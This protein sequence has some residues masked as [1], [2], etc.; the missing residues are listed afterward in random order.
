MTL[1]LPLAMTLSAL[2]LGMK[3]EEIFA[4][5]TYNAAC[6]LGLEKRKGAILPGYDS[7]FIEAPFSRF[8]EIYYRFGWLPSGKA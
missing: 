6:A 4:A 8:E 1:N 2:Y 7:D 5:V 3:R